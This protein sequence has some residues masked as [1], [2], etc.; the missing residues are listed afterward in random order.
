MTIQE[1]F[2]FRGLWSPGGCRQCGKPFDAANS[3]LGP[4]WMLCC[5]N[6]DTYRTHYRQ[7][8]PDGP[9]Q[10][11]PP[12]PPY[13]AYPVCT[14]TETLIFLHRVRRREILHHEGTGDSWSERDGFGVTRVVYELLLFRLV[15]V[16]LMAASRLVGDQAGWRPLRLTARGVHLLADDQRRTLR[17]LQGGS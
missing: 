3:L 12:V 17:M 2:D 5:Q 7:F 14:A 6:C 16:D 11:C 8:L 10:A 15:R 4:D 13:P 1:A 9:C